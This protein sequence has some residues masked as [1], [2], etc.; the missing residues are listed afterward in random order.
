MATTDIRLSIAHQ[1]RFALRLASAISSPSNPD[2][3]AGNAVFS[4]LSLHVALS[5]VA[6]GAGGA[7]R[8]QLAAALGADGP[9]EAEKLHALAERVVQLV[10]ADASAEGGPR[11]AFANSVFADSSMPLKPSFKEIA[12]GKY[13]AETN[14][15]DFQTKVMCPLLLI[16][17][18][19]QLNTAILY[20]SRDTN[21]ILLLLC[22][23]WKVLLRNILYTYI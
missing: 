23:G 19:V 7:T 11:V 22:F 21:S 18:S 8:D 4:P 5:L 12:V 10:V 13:K 16:T 14:S 9:G 6:A 17:R 15:V 20:Y 3:A 1:T 2:G